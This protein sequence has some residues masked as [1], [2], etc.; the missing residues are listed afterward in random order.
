MSESMKRPPLALK[1]AEFRHGREQ[2]W[3]ALEALLERVDRRGIKSLSADELEQLPL[4][5]RAAL[6]SLSVARAIALDRHL[7][8]Y[9]ENLA[10]RAYLVVYSPRQLLF[11]GAREFFRSGLPAAVQSIRG[12]LLVSLLTTLAG[13]VAGFMLTTADETWLY[14]FVD[15]GLLEGRGP[16]STRQDLLSH[17]IFAPWPGFADSFLLFANYLFQH[18]AEVAILCFGLGIAAGVPTLL[19]LLMNG[20]TLGAFLALHYDRGLL[21]DFVGWLSIHGVTEIG[22]IIL[23]GAGGLLIAEKILFPGRYSRVESLAQ[24]GGQ[25]SRIAIGAVLLLILA[26]ILEGGFRQLVQN[27][28][29]RLS[30]GFGVAACWGYYF[31]RPLGDRREQTAP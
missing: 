1:S 7:L 11:A 18:N 15:R 10:L 20:L 12:H 19:L 24:I 30:I 8:L 13:C 16:D 9:L 27:T 17:E 31:A 28:P 22:A 4:L 29:A 5:Y 23:A 21:F 14:T 2:S 6:S 26:G 3:V 25:A